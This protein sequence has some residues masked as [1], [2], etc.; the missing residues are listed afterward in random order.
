VTSVFQKLWD[1][2]LSKIPQLKLCLTGSLVGMMEREV[3]AYKAPLYGRATAL[4]K[5]RPLPYAALM[6]LF[7]ERE[8]AERVAIYA[9]CGGIPAYLD[10]FTRTK[11]F[12]TALRSHCLAPGSLMLSDPALL[13]Y[14]QL[15]EPQKYES[16]LWAIASGHHQWKEI[17]LLAGVPEG[18]I[19]HYINV[20]TDL[21][22]IE[23]HDPVLSRLRGRQ[24]RYTVRDDFLR[25]YYRFV[26]PKMSAIEQGQLQVVAQRIQADLR[27]FIGANTFERLCR[28]WVWAAAATGELAWLPEEVGSFWKQARGEGVQLDV[29]AANR[30]E[31]RLLIGEAK[32][33]DHLVGRG[34]LTDLLARSRRMPQVAQGWKVEYILF[35]RL[36]FSEAAK[37][38]AKELGARLL[39]LAEMEKTLAAANR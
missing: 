39:P 22:V 33:V 31:K 23:R 28:E 32:W 16:V 1:H 3:L 12:G 2:R 18:S 24:G 15:R 7:P 5:L 17:A 26:A 37:A 35:S 6:E 13:L 9:V 25:F 11:T 20:L 19:G 27:P 10:L 34:L 8:P 38:E 36:G 4:Y 29:V 21:E 30:A 14:E